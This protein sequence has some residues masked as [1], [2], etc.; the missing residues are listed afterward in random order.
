MV[1]EFIAA[2][3][4]RDHERAS[5]LLAE[6]FEWRVSPSAGP[7]LHG[8]QARDGLV[9]GLSKKLTRPGTERRV[10]DRVTADGGAVL[11]EYT[12]TA[13]TVGGQEYTNGYCWLYDV[14]DGLISRITNYSDS[15]GG[16]RAFGA[17]TVQAGLTAIRS[18]KA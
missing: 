10:I 11:V 6:D 5:A 9:G 18:A 7:P 1:E 15:L 14:T 4:D 3:N 17:D 13:I 8:Q 12:I 2:R 16:W